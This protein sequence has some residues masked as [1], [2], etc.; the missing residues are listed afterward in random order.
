MP[1][2]FANAFFAVTPTDSVPTSEEM[3]STL[4]GETT[5]DR[6]S[7]LAAMPGTEGRVA[8][9]PMYGAKLEAAE[10]SLYG[11]CISPNTEIVSFKLATCELILC[12]AESS[13][14]VILKPL[15]TTLLQSA[16]GSRE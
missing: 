16:K 9:G 12:P 13:K 8:S 7:T 10:N 1:E 6:C 11:R 5:V 14:A 4:M 3:F 15:F 2:M